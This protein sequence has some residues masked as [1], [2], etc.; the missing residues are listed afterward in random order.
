MLKFR[1]RFAAGSDAP[2]DGTAN[3]FLCGRHPRRKGESQEWMRSC[4]T[5]PNISQRFAS[6][7]LCPQL[8][9]RTS[10]S[11]NMGSLSTVASQ[12]T[13]TMIQCQK[14]PGVLH[15]HRW[16]HIS[17]TSDGTVCLSS[18][19][20]GKGG[21][22]PNTHISSSSSNPF[23]SLERAKDRG[24]HP[25]KEVTSGIFKDIHAMSL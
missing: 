6:S 19:R 3:L 13:R 15:L 18:S 20:P 11:A 14:N 7:V 5:G 1:I 22:N 10:S 21:F 2:D 9:Q 25:F 23:L 17:R 12:A 8:S 4:A 16:L 24:P